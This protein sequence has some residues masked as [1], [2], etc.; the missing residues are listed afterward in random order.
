MSWAIRASTAL[1]GFS[2]AVALASRLQFAAQPHEPVSALKAAGYSPA[3]LVLQFVGGVVLTALFAIAGERVARLLRDFRSAAVSYCGVLLLAPVS[4]MYWGNLRHVIMLGAFAAAIVALRR[5]DPRFTR[6]DVILIPIVFSCTIAFLELGFGRTPLA[7]FLRAAIA[8][9]ALRLLVRS[10][11]AFLLTPLAL[12]FQLGLLTPVAGATLALL[13]IAATPFL[14]IRAA[15]RVIYPIVV[16]LYPLAAMTLPPPT[17]AD[18][19]EDSHNIP[20]ATEMLRGERPYADIIPTHGFLSDAVIDYAAMKFGVT[21]YRTLLETRTVLGALSAVGIYCLIFAAT[22]RAE[23]GLA[24]VFLAFNLFSGSTLWLRPSIALFA[25][26]AT[27]AATRLR[28]PRFFIAAGALSFFAYLMSIDFGVY[29]TVVALFAG[30]RMRSLRHVALG[31]AGA[32]LPTLL[33]FAL[34][35]FA[36]DFVRVSFVEILGGHGAY[37]VQPLAIPQ[38]LRST[39]LLHN[40]PNCLNPMLWMAAL[41]T[42]CAALARTPWRGR[43]SDAPWL[44]GVWL[45]VAAASFVE[46]ANFHFN[47]AITPFVVAAL[48]KLSRVARPVAVSLTVAV[49]LLADPFRHPMIV[50][51]ELRQARPGP[52]FDPTTV[53]AI[54]AAKRFG[55]TLGADETFVDFSNSALLYALLGRDCPLRY[56]EVANY[57]SVEAQREVI[58]T[59]ERNP[60]VRGAL[61]AFAGS[62][63]RVDGIPNHERAPL[64]WAYL[65]REFT[66]AFDESGVVVWRR[67]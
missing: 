13:T 26:A 28:S 18:F 8:I 50:L 52:L 22:G 14:R 3:G 36:D 54:E 32:A 2:L 24:G 46:R 25:L 43:R 64:V 9:L 7:A 53:A 21:S 19:F 11:D 29:S 33:V 45:V 31:L 34:F 12:V 40:L 66:P 1:F 39:A 41:L 42:T 55:A 6:G 59:I 44:I 49:V 4:L 63:Q 56:V 30:F 37:F 47:P 38:C 10:A 60:K 48:W 27:V 23:V 16:Y 51:P 61:I 17:A 65:Q 15:R 5:R 58:A 20:V 57:Q 62:N 35:G 67:R